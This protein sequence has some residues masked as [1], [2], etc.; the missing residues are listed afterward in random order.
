[1]AFLRRNKSSSMRG[2]NG[3]SQSAGSHTHT[4]APRAADLTVGDYAN[5]MP[6][7]RLG[8]MLKSFGR[9]LIWVVPLFLIGSLLAWHLTRDFKRTFTGDARILV[10]IG[11]EYV[12][13]PITG[14]PGQAGMT[15]TADTIALN[16]VGIIK[17]DEIIEQVFGEMTSETSPYAKRFDPAG[18]KKLREAGNNQRLRREARSEMFRKMDRAFMVAPRPK[19][20]IIDLSYKHEDGEVAVATLNALILAY[21]SYRRKIFVEGAAGIIGE[22]RKE[23][24]LQLDQNERAIARFLKRNNISDFN[25]EQGGVRKRTEELRAALNLLRAQM[26]ETETALATVEGQLR[27]TP[28]EINL[29]I[30]DRASARVSQAELELKQLLAKY[31]PSSDPVRQKQTELAELKSLLS[32]NGGRATGGRRVGPNTV[33]QAL[34]TRRNTLQATAD[35]YREKE[36]T[37]QRQLNS[38]DAKVRK[39]TALSPDYA[40]LLRE[41]ESLDS[42]LKNY[43]AKEQEAL[44]KQ[45]QAEAT[46]ENVKVI[47]WPKYPNKGSN[48]RLLAAAGA[49]FAWGLTLFMLALLRVFLDPRLYVAPTSRINSATAPSYIPEPVSPYV[50]EQTPYEPAV[51]SHEP[52][53]YY[54]ESYDAGQVQQGYDQGN[55]AATGQSYGQQDYSQ[56]QYA[57]SN[58]AQYVAGQDSY[59]QGA[60]M[61]DGT[62]PQ[63]Y[64]PY[65]YSSSPFDP[66]PYT[67]GSAALDMNSNP[68]LSGQSAG[69]LDQNGQYT[70][71]QQDTQTPKI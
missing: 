69:A 63:P 23:T 14:Q 64:D 45:K 42:R 56:P 37:L 22:S 28:K 15:I 38:A 10:Q 17:N 1:M 11:D 67:D 12:Y 7:I 19:S 25:S 59:M 21:Q 53:A 49:I 60:V 40:S 65:T 71:G 24:E 51:A 61:Q 44:V 62:G 36:F 4:E 8:E 52:A 16:E 30:D 20:S 18:M 58:T 48:T 27:Q 55:Y 13:Q 34:L 39:L 33:Y 47:S 3:G 50:P 26:S 41:R 2:H 66:T 43:N 32:A 29:Y 54:P 31:L 6:N 57:D 46:N 35:S 70:Q 5:G 68:Y 9:Q